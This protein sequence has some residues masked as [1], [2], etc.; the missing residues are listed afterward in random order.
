MQNIPTDLMRSFVKAVDGG[1]F[2]RAAEMVG[3]TQ[4]A[5]SLQIKRLEDLVRAPLFQRD[6]HKLQ[7]TAQG[8]IFSQYARRML[9]LNDEV[10]ALMQS[11]PVSGRIRLGAPSEYTDSLL[12]HLL[13][14]FAQSHPNVILEVTSDLSKNLLIRQ[15]N[16]EF[17]LVIGLHDDGLPDE[18]RPI[19]TEPLVWFTSADHAA[20]DML[21]VPLVLAPPPC[22]YRRRMLHYLNTE[23][24][25]CR[26]SY[27]SSSQSALL[28]AVR[29]GLG[30]TAMA[31]S[32]VPPD[33]HILD[34]TE[35]LAKLG[36]LEVRL[37]RTYT[38]NSEEAI[39]HLETYIAE[40]L[41][42]ASER[43]FVG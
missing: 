32:T 41:R 37:H 22:I 30:V 6:A 40:R 26:I 11:P 13:G 35:N 18:G 27:V 28:A 12:P 42:Q 43:G 8:R 33:V 29:A 19:H 38:A 9:A 20:Q 36:D 3:R 24:R 39:D 14:R 7:L 5:I 25:S 17:D 23:K 10:L 34:E 4:S 21:P 15:K 31:R 2:T 16:G 1:S